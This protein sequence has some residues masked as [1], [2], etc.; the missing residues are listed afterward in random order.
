VVLLRKSIPQN[1]NLKTAAELGVRQKIASEEITM[2]IILTL[3]IVAVFAGAFSIKRLIDMLKSY[4]QSYGAEIGKIDATTRKLDEIQIQLA[5][6]V[7]ISESIKSDIQHGAWRSR[8]LE[9]LKRQKL[10]E[11]LLHYYEAVE[12]LTKK[13]REMFFDDKTPYNKLCEAKISM[14]QKL[15][16]PELDIEHI[17]FL[18]ASANFN[19]W[20]VI[21]MQEL[22]EKR[23]LGNK[24]AVISGEHMEK[25]SELL[26]EVNKATL[27]IETKAKEIGRSINVA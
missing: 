23:R 15:Y 5:Q 18:K 13:T 11:Y 8:E 3:L 6:S 20:I 21:G 24:F 12:N 7:K 4:S 25:Y 17:S 10:E 16:I 26:A 1:H 22:Q 9:L 14:L 19:G 27:L 2:E